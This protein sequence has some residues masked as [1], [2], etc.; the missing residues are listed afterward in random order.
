MKMLVL[1]YSKTGNNR[2]VAEE[3][4][5]RLHADLEEIKPEKTLTMGRIILDMMFSRKPKLCPLKHRVSSYDQI[6]LLGP[7]WMG[8]IASPVYS[9]IKRYRSEL[10]KL[11]FLS[12]AGGAL[13]RNE[14]V[15]AQI[16]KLCK[17]KVGIVGQMYANDLLT[18]E[19]KG[20]MEETSVFKI[21]IEHLEKDLAPDY[22]SFLK[23][24][25]V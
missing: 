13:N 24:V 22:S 3:T 21:A 11:S 1:Y 10:S 8:K 14:K 5:K 9:F 4:A 15:E 23:K 12:M 2:I 19:Q 16:K 18:E 7:I 6:I 20:K 17:E 25:V